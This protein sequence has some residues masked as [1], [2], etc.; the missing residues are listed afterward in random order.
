MVPLLERV[1]A[2]HPQAELVELLLGNSGGGPS[3]GLIGRVPPL[4]RRPPSTA[5]MAERD[6]D[7]KISVK[8]L[9]REWDTSHLRAA[10]AGK[11]V[12]LTGND[13]QVGRSDEINH[14]D[15]DDAEE[16]PVR[17]KAKTADD[18]ESTGMYEQQRLASAEEA[19]AASK[20]D[21]T[22]ATVSRTLKEVAELV[23][24]SLDPPICV[25]V[26]A[27][28]TTALESTNR[29]DAESGKD[30]ETDQNAENDEEA[31]GDNDGDDGGQE[32]RV[33]K[34]APILLK[35]EP[36]SLLSED[37]FHGPT[38][39]SEDQDD[40]ESNKVKSVALHGYGAGSELKA[41]LACLLQQTPALRYRHVAVS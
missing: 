19:V 8:M 36:D 16:E 27:D 3:A 12:D 14:S 22:E 30:T 40:E 39:S 18:K 32:V 11:K 13:D 25:E 6:R 26:D 41:T 33:Q 10:L 24:A 7:G 5:S 34:T 1:A 15:E 2:S 35:L 28:A 4:S 38:T 31:A 20:Q 21:T 37:D 23:L 17:K 29:V 9:S